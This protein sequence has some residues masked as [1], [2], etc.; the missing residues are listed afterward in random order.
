MIQTLKYGTNIAFK[1]NGDVSAEKNK[2]TLKKRFV[3]VIKGVNDVTSTTKG[4][5]RG[6]A[7]GVA[8]TAL[9]GLVGKNIK[10]AKANIF[11][12][13]TGVLKDTAKAAWNVVKFV[14]ALITKSPA[15]NIKNVAALPNKFYKNYLKNTKTTALI[16]TL[17]GLGIVAFRTIQGKIKANIKNADVDHATKTKHY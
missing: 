3:D 13:T 6:I 10:E 11:K 12:S 17:A 9:V 14:P 4:A 1:G 5:T 7:E 15:E 8:V 2:P 16:A